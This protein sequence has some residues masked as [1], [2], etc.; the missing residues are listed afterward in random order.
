MPRECADDQEDYSTSVAALFFAFLALF[1]IV[2]MLNLLIA[3]MSDSCG[4]HDDAT[5]GPTALLCC[6][7][8]LHERLSR[9]RFGLC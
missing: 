6:C 4:Q 2:M 9:Q 3:I 7:S 8:P 1:A 5:R